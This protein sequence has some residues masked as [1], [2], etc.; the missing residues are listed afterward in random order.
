MFVSECRRDPRLSRFAGHNGGYAP[1]STHWEAPFAMTRTGIV[2]HLLVLFAT[3]PAA[4]A[5]PATPEEA[6]EVARAYLQLVIAKFGGWGDQADASL[7]RMR[8]LR[9][10]GR[11]L[12]YV[13]D[14][15]PDGFMVVSRHKEIAAVKAFSP[16][17]RFEPEAQ[18]GVPALVRDRLV[19]TIEAIEAT[20]GK[21]IEDVTAADW[22]ARDIEHHRQMW[23]YLVSSDFQPSAHTRYE[24]H[25]TAPGM[26]YQEGEVMLDSHWH[27]RPPYNDQCPDLGC[28]WSGSPFF[29]YNTRARVGCAGIAG[30]QAT[31]FWAWPSC[32][33]DGSYV[34]RYWWPLMPSVVD[35][36]SPQQ[37][38]DAVA[39]ACYSFAESMDSDFGCDA[40]GANLATF[41]DVFQ[42]R[43]YHSGCSIEARLGHT[44]A[45]WFDL[46]KE[47]CNDNQ[48]SIYYVEDHFTVL[49]GWSEVWVG[50]VLTERWLHFNYGW[51]DAGNNTWYLMDTW[52]HGM[53]IL[54]RIVRGIRPDVSLWDLSGYYPLPSDPGVHFDKPVRYFKRDAVGTNATFE[55]GHSFQYLRPGFW[56]RNTG[57]LSD[58]LVFNG[59]TSHETEF[60]HRAPYGDVRIKIH[61]GAIKIRGGG[62][63]CFR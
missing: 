42:N 46:C 37:Q 14:V 11:L 33:A 21:A 44:S 62:E 19:R 13:F 48:V 18:G 26:N 20:T 7:G 61:D 8:E 24:R 2:A 3:L 25:R 23:D 55:A 50:G 52:P 31:R 54:E 30:V 51:Y 1:E 27:Q 45:W 29:G 57:G 49:D 41:E 28:D 34:D 35:I 36:Y 59:E 53:G 60:Y 38:I 12:A 5:E 10:G 16:E 47:Q 56:L 6:Q 43:R 39:A 15:E 58:A 22:Q 17:G 63:I 4:W 9:G 32:A 40:T